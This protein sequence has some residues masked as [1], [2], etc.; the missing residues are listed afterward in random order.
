ME[1]SDAG[2]LLFG[3]GERDA[4]RHAGVKRSGGAK[5]MSGT[6]AT[7]KSDDRNATAP[8]ASIE[9]TSDAMLAGLN[10][11]QTRCVTYDGKALVVLAGPGT[12]KTRVIT[13]RIA[14]LVKERGIAPEQI[15]AATFTVKAA[16]ELRERLGKLLTPVEAERVRASTLHGLGANIVRRFGVELGLPSRIVMIDPA[17]RR[18][19]VKRAIESL[20]IF[21]AERIEGLTTIAERVEKMISRMADSGVLPSRALTFASE[22]R[23][24]GAKAF[25]GPRDERPAEVAMQEL[26]HFEQMARAYDA[27]CKECWQRGLLSFHD[28]LL[29]PLKLLRDKPGVRAL[30]QSEIKALVIDEFQDCNAG[31][32]EFAKLL[33]PP[34]SSGGSICVVGDDDQAIYA[35][36]GA[37]Q[38]AFERFADIWSQHDVIA[39]DTNYR[40]GISII[41]AGNAIITRAHHRFRP[42]KT[43]HA[44]ADAGSGAT[45]LVSLDEE[46][47]DAPVVAAMIVMDRMQRLAAGE[48][49][50]WSDYAVIARTH[51]H[52]DHLAGTL[53]LEGVPWERQR[54]LGILGES[55]VQ[56]VL[57]WVE[58]LLTPSATWCAR[59]I[60]TRAPYGL[61]AQLVLQ[62]E[63]AYR[64]ARKR[65][66]LGAE[67]VTHPGEYA[68]WLSAHVQTLTGT[69][70]ATAARVLALHEAMRRELLSIAGD[71]ALEQVMQR[72]GAAHAEL[73]P[74]RERAARVR[75][76]VTLLGL[77]RTRRASFDAPGDLRSFWNYFNELRE[78]DPELRSVGQLG[79]PEDAVEKDEDTDA[80]DGEGQGKVQLLT[81]HSSKG[82]E[83]DTVFV[84]RVTP[85]HGFPKKK[86]DDADAE[87]PAGLIDAATTLDADAAHRDEERRLF[88]V[89]CTRAKRRLVLLA[90]HKGK[91]STAVMHLFD[92]MLAAAEVSTT[93]VRGTDVLAQA[94]RAGVRVSGRDELTDASETGGGARDVYE[95]MRREARL[96]AAA[97]CEQ[98]ESAGAQEKQPDDT[99]LAEAQRAL[100]VTATQLAIIAGL[101]HGTNEQ[102]LRAMA[103][104]H[105]DS[106]S[107]DELARVLERVLRA[108]TREAHTEARHTGLRTIKPPLRLSYSS[109]D[110]YQRCPRC[111]YLKHVVGLPELD[112]NPQQLGNAAHAALEQFY[113]A[114]AL[115]DAEG[116]PKPALHDL[117]RMGKSALLRELATLEL[118]ERDATLG[119]QLGQLS[120]QLTTCYRSLHEE[121][122]M[123]LE[124]ERTVVFPYVVDGVEHTFTAK[125]DRVDQLPTGGFRVIDYKAG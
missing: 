45:E 69:P 121:S 33:C 86:N 55:G 4:A 51:G 7:K 40:S 115:A 9:S 73:L 106:A 34:G 10:P 1:T 99:A 15:V 118:H 47:G 93:R 61:D 81:A 77:A 72:T 13:H 53:S 109:L 111:W 96:R 87:L 94:E 64:D 76:L 20:G 36:R 120:A 56:D 32:I 19:I 14:W 88:Y 100:A 57:A 28:L 71:E 66:E 29:L 42:D 16:R 18:R 75:A 101:E 97:A 26:E 82:L 67:G 78:A 24:N 11:A 104:R 49:A 60:L 125:I 25:R 17:Q 124:T 105:A 122:A 79:E 92:E 113:Q 12:G 74:Q 48:D 90:K 116:N 38:F 8:A 114:W 91:R 83:F 70:A 65:A 54:E 108:R 62:W 27:V 63:L 30:V 103:E 44:R 58:W 23:A 80:R 46:K 39:L 50:S 107:R 117:L 6:R 31:Q 59:R 35:F 102:S 119:E 5:T 2:S 110:A 89:A 37:D 123:V 68:T 52:L 98:A 95:A 22:Q 41:G 112:S 84:C 85:P 21:E 3:E 43:M